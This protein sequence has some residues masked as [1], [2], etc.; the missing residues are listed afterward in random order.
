MTAQP[1][2]F[3][4]YIGPAVHAYVTAQDDTEP[5]T[6]VRAQLSHS[7]QGA[8]AAHQVAT[9]DPSSPPQ[10]DA[11]QIAALDRGARA[12]TVLVDD[13]SVVSDGKRE[14]ETAVR[15]KKKKRKRSS[16]ANGASQSAAEAEAEAEA[17][18]LAALRRGTWRTG[19]AV[20]KKKKKG[21]KKA[22]TAAAAT[23]AAEAAEFSSDGE[24][25]PVDDLQLPSDDD[26][27]DEDDG[28]DYEA[29]GFCVLD[30]D[31]DDDDVAT[32]APAATVSAKDEAAREARRARTRARVAAEIAAAPSD[33]FGEAEDEGSYDPSESESG[34][35]SESESDADS[36]V[37]VD[38]DRAFA[39]PTSNPELDLTNLRKAVV[40]RVRQMLS[41][42]VRPD[43]AYI[44]RA[45]GAF[46]NVCRIALA[47]KPSPSLNAMFAVSKRAFG[48]HPSP[49]DEMAAAFAAL[50]EGDDPTLRCAPQQAP[51][52][53]NL[54]GTVL[55]GNR[56]M[57]LVGTHIGASETRP[58]HCV[59]SDRAIAPGAPCVAIFIGTH[60]PAAPIAR[61]LVDPV[62]VDVLEH[63]VQMQ[64]W[65]F[66]FAN[67]IYAWREANDPFSPDQ[68]FK[69]RIHY[70]L[71]DESGQQVVAKAVYEF[72]RLRH[73][74]L[75][76][77]FA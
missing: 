67:C 23:L 26:D 4:L 11:A 65:P 66:R 27:E 77:T 54:L 63:V 6:G 3:K 41:E 24:I 20:T 16:A 40:L 48:A 70:M 68:T 76:R 25:G 29:D 42:T 53:I 46:I 62:G 2:L 56:P 10:M 9:V 43:D 51:M 64:N 60:D 7:T 13:D 58:R 74:V 50:F 61:L 72:V 1:S 30:D 8:I 37:S 38:D 32:D 59:W 57:R 17:L 73:A 52:V 28:E 39:P 75:T 34:S 47:Q 12:E 44:D 35:E 36:D 71:S 31:D 14:E 49:S 55:E 15:T 18:Q 5:A 19:K 22:R 21:K 69:Q 45:I 33:A